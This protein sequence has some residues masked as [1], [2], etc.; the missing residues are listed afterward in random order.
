MPLTL[1]I[2]ETPDRDRGDRRATGQTVELNWI[3]PS[4]A[5]ATSAIAKPIHLFGRVGQENPGEE[6][7]PASPNRGLLTCHRLHPARPDSGENHQPQP[8]RGSHSSR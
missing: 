3:D 2:H 7:A 4:E 5:E 1:I 8:D 6:I